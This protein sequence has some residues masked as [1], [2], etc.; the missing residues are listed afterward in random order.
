MH[1][2]PTSATAAERPDRVG[3][4]DFYASHGFRESGEVD[5]GE[6]VIELAS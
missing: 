1:C 3:P 2:D 4:G 6:F 5:E